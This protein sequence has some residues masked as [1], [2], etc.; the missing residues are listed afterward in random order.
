MHISIRREGFSNPVH[1][2][3]REREM[4]STPMHAGTGHKNGVS[5]PWLVNTGRRFGTGRRG[6]VMEGWRELRTWST[7]DSRAL[8]QQ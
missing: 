2:S 7:T 5:T 6:G 3:V 1:A 4:I 8:G